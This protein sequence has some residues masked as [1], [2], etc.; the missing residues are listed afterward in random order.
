MNISFHEFNSIMDNI[1]IVILLALMVT[2]FG[3]GVLSILAMR[4]YLRRTSIQPIEDIIGSKYLPGISVIAPAYNEGLTIVEN[5]RSLLSLSYADF[6]IIIVNDGST[7]NSL[8]KLIAAFKLIPVKYITTASLP[9]QAIRNVY[10]SSNPA[11]SHLVV[12]DKVNGGK[13]DALNVG[14]NLSSKKLVLC[15]DVDC[16]IESDGLLKL[17]RPFLEEKE[18][19]VVAVGG[20]IRVVN[21]CKIK[22]GKVVEVNLPDGWLERFQ[23]VE[24]FRVFNIARMG[25][26]HIRALLIIS[27][28]LGLFDKDLLIRAGGYTHGTVGEDMELVIK[29]HRYMCEVEKKKYVVEYIPDPICWTEVPSD[30]KI[31]GKQRNRWGRGFLSTTI[32][33]RKVLF[34]PKYGIIGMLSY[35]VTFFLEWVL[36]PIEL[37]GIGY[38]VYMFFTDQLNLPYFLLMFIALYSF[39]M[40]ITL[41][42]I[43]IEESTYHHYHKKIDVI[44]LVM[45]AMIEPFFYQPLNFYW[46]IKGNYDYFF[47]KGK[48]VWGSME[49]K[50]FT[51]EVKL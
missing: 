40:M 47:K 25:W 35:P 9:T 43:L 38:I 51:S 2:Y 16:I 17:V 26:A 29:L 11:Y 22:E 50:G 18:Y 32:A 3:L 15:I 41:L 13:S 21:S 19:R 44:K 5:A 34:N 31:L 23:V 20:V 39:F 27:G 37:L 28:A 8:S 7:D 33:H 1:F 45:I 6:E 36:L 24:Y 46:T 42:S 4:K 14:V 10:K 48:H 30:F 12:V 49:R